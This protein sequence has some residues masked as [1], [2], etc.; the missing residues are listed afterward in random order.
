[1]LRC[2][3][4][5]Q[6][7]MCTMFTCLYLCRVMTLQNV[8]ELSEV[9]VRFLGNKEKPAGIL[10]VCEQTVYSTGI[11]VALLIIVIGFEK[12][13]HLEWN[14]DLGVVTL[15][16]RAVSKLPVAL[17]L[18]FVAVSGREIHTFEV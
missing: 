2:R 8:L 5:L 16:E 18:K 14:L 12:R 10:V 17:C 4:V 15:Y 11:Q 13:A 7:C 3:K 9:D 6:S 1:M